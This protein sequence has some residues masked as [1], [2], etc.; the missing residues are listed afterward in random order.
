MLETLLPEE[1]HFLLLQR[2]LI[3]G[4]VEKRIIIIG[5]CRL[6]LCSGRCQVKTGIGLFL[7]NAGQFPDSIQGMITGDYEKIGSEIMQ[8][9]QGFPLFPDL[10]ENILD[11]LFGKFPGPCNGK[12]E[13]TQL[14]VVFIENASEGAFITLSNC[15]EQGLIFQRF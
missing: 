11:D 7:F 5:L 15:I 9:W 6:F 4:I 13:A 8:S 2:E 12:N 14:L 3:N 10:Q 1:I